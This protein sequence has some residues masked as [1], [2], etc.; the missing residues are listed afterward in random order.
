MDQT[1]STAKGKKAA[2]FHIVTLSDSQI[3]FIAKRTGEMTIS[4]GVSAF[5]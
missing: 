1:E 4:P 3:S 5:S 2:F